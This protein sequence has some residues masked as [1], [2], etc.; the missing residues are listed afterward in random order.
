MS[1]WGENFVQP[2]TLNFRKCDRVTLHRQQEND[3]QG[4]CVS[5]AALN[6]SMKI[7]KRPLTEKECFLDPAEQLRG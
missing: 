7:G 3:T 5:S 1:L 6:L 2:I 4:V